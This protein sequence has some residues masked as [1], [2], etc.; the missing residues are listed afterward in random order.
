[1]LNQLV[2]DGIFYWLDEEVKESYKLA[3]SVTGL[4]ASRYDDIILAVREYRELKDFSP[5]LN[6]RTFTYSTSSDIRRRSDII[7]ALNAAYART[8]TSSVVSKMYISFLFVSFYDDNAEKFLG[9][10][11]I[12]VQ[13]RKEAYSYSKANRIGETHYDEATDSVSLTPFMVN[14]ATNTDAITRKVL[15]TIDGMLDSI[16]P[17]TEGSGW[18]FLGLHEMI[19]RTSSA[20][21]ISGERTASRPR[22]PLILDNGTFEVEPATAFFSSRQQQGLTPEQVNAI[23]INIAEAVENG[24]TYEDVLLDVPELAEILPAGGFPTAG[25]APAPLQRLRRSARIRDQQARIPRRSSR[26]TRPIA[27]FVPSSSNGRIRPGRGFTAGSYTGDFKDAFP[28]S[29][30]SRMMGIIQ[31]RNRDTQVCFFDAI[32]LFFTR[33]PLVARGRPPIDHPE[34]VIYKKP[35]VPNRASKADSLKLFS[36]FYPDFGDSLPAIKD[37]IRDYQGFDLFEELADFSFMIQHPI[38]IHEF[39]EEDLELGEFSGR[40]ELL[41]HTRDFMPPEYEEIDDTMSDEEITRF[42]ETHKSRR[43]LANTRKFATPNEKRVCLKDYHTECALKKIDHN[44]TIHLL[45]HN[46]HISLIT[47]PRTYCDA[48]WCDKCSHIVNDTNHGYTA[49]LRK[50]MMHKNC[51]CSNEVNRKFYCA[52][53]VYT[54]KGS[55]V[56]RLLGLNKLEGKAAVDIDHETDYRFLFKGFCCLDFEAILHR[57]SDFNEQ[58]TEDGKTIK[59]TQVY[60]TH[61]ACL[62]TISHNLNP[63]GVTETFDILNKKDDEHGSNQ[64]FIK[65]IMRV[66]TKLSEMNYE[67]NKAEQHFIDILEDPNVSEEDKRRLDSKMHML[68]VMTVNGGGYDM[69]LIADDILRFAVDLSGLFDD[70]DPSEYIRINNKFRMDYRSKMK[71]KDRLDN[72]TKKEIELEDAALLEELDEDNIILNRADRKSKL[73]KVFTPI[74]KGSNY[75]EMRF[76]SLG[77]TI[78]DITLIFK[79]SLDTILRTF[80]SEGEQKGYFPYEKCDSFAYL[81]KVHGEPGC[82]FP[83]AKEDFYSELKQRN[84]LHSVPRVVNDTDRQKEEDD[85]DIAEMN[86]NYEDVQKIW[87]EAGMTTMA[88]YCVWYGRRDV[89]PLITAIEA[90]RRLFAKDGMDIL[91]DVLTMPGLGE[92]CMAYAIEEFADLDSIPEYVKWRDIFNKEL[93]HPE[94]VMTDELRKAYMRIKLRFESLEKWITEI[95]TTMLESTDK[96]TGEKKKRK[97][98]KQGYAPVNAMVRE[99]VEADKKSMACLN[100]GADAN[101]VEG[102]IADNGPII[103]KNIV[104]RYCKQQNRCDVCLAP[105]VIAAEQPY[106]EN[107]KFHRNICSALIRAIDPLKGLTLDNFTLTCHDCCHSIRKA[108]L[109]E[110]GEIK[111]ARRMYAWAEDKIIMMVPKAEIFDMLKGPGGPTFVMHRHMNV[112]GVDV[113]GDPIDYTTDWG[114]AIGCSDN[115]ERFHAFQGHDANALYPYAL[116]QDLPCGVLKLEY[117]GQEYHNPGPELDE[118]ARKCANDEIYGMIEVDIFLPR[119]LWEQFPYLQPLFIT[120]KIPET[121]DVIGPYTFNQINAKRVKVDGDIKTLCCVYRA[122]KTVLSTTMIKDLL[123]YG[124]KLRAAYRF[125]KAT[126]AK[127][128]RQFIRTCSDQRRFGDLAKKN[129]PIADASKLKANGCFGRTLI[130]KTKFDVDSYE[131]DKSTI[132][133]LI[134]MKTFLHGEVIKTEDGVNDIYVIKSR[135]ASVH[136]DMPIQLGFTVFMESKRLMLAFVYKFLQPCLGLGNYKL[137]YMDTD[138]EIVAYTGESLEASV[139]PEMREYYETNKRDFLVPNVRDSTIDVIKYYKKFM[140]D[141]M[142]IEGEEDEIEFNDDLTTRS[143]YEYFGHGGKFSIYKETL[144]LMTEEEIT[145]PDVAEKLGTSF[146]VYMSREPG[147]F[148]L[149]YEGTKGSFLSAKSYHMRNN[150]PEKTVILGYKIGSM[151]MY[152]E[153]EKLSPEIFKE[154]LLDVECKYET[155]YQKVTKGGSKGINKDANVKN[156]TSDAHYAAIKGEVKTGMNN[157]IGMTNHEMQTTKMEKKLF[158]TVYKKKWLED[159]GITCR[160]MLLDPKDGLYWGPNE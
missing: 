103:C 125:I 124:L 74:M 156:L 10:E 45:Y 66:L 31:I 56:R 89:D 14:V 57:V 150:G 109:N 139:L 85:K 98:G 87:K 69:K 65:E 27:R 52:P 47:D 110:I 131:I 112:E 134:S 101:I 90:M 71:R 135:N 35:K 51:G 127:C 137:L 84:V 41:F 86:K 107:T 143:L 149:E 36:R 39:I 81:R 6:S 132:K 91:H 15:A 106:D 99:T 9:N 7:P 105:F 145:R 96:V 122:R 78:R 118:L 154:S 73:D 152:D 37:A 28:A 21:T 38:Y 102:I 55:M 3:P 68:P 148:K 23:N 53:E 104:Q 146:S 62:A 121:A 75:V 160:Y 70:V 8:A 79:G 117:L 113:N 80:A 141:D 29:Q 119:Y 82:D 76:P 147:L 19:I 120:T 43:H 40:L 4:T 136:M 64:P 94:L 12:Q 155:E 88:E 153:D 2:L 17:R 100:V 97:K 1:M 133:R 130:D 151:K 128:V 93:I 123:G 116:Q 129:K 67:N 115:G 60:T 159:D 126:P 77:F 22:V 49:N 144:K 25:I 142:V 46:G 44:R 50:L 24:Q 158:N 11:R 61:D 18:T 72:K 34:G 26:V 108:Y 30:I 16:Q 95:N 138:C 42:F 32:A 111:V 157:R 33:K 48:I 83:V 13:G 20:G 59:K 58:L 54:K 63:D 5:F 114:K 92:K 140:R